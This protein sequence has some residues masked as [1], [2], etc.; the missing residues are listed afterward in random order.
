MTST[1]VIIVG[2]GL[3]GLTLARNLTEQGIDFLVLEGRERVGGRIHSVETQCGAV[4]EMGATWFFPRFNNLLKLLK[5]L[6]VEL[7]EQYSIGH[8]MYESHARMQARK[9]KSSEGDL[10]RIKGGT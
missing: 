4:V 6:K 1:D 2:A 5:K 10:F 3:T 7:S 8:T 9:I